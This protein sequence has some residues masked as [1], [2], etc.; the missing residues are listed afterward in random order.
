MFRNKLGGMS[1]VLAAALCLTVALSS[2][3]KQE[4]SPDLSLVVPEAA[5]Y[6]TTTVTVGD[7]VSEKTLPATVVYLDSAELTVE[8]SGAK[9]VEFLVE[10]DQQVEA[11]DPILTYQVEGSQADLTEKKLR[12]QEVENDYARQSSGYQSQI[13]RL[14][15]S[16]AECTKGTT[17]Y[18]LVNCNLKLVQSQANQLK[19][20]TAYQKEQ[21]KKEIEEAAEKLDVQ[22]LYA[23]FSG[24][25]SLLASIAEGDLIEN[26]LALC[27]MRSADRLLLQVENNPAF[28]YGDTVRIK[29]GLLS[30]AEG[31]EGRVVTCGRILP[32]KVSERVT[33]IELAD[34]ADVERLKLASGNLMVTADVVNLSDVLL[35]T[36]DAITTKNERDS[37]SLL[38]EDVLNQRYIS[39]GSKG[40]EESWVIGGLEEGQTV[41]VD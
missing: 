2:C 1:G 39:V 40:E 6:Q 19:L 41:V 14:K 34:S 33:Y 26:N 17:D 4:D 27:T 16:L 5:N 24:T 13:T 18:D 21:L 7:F 31:Y 25:V 8:E 9:F 10:R 12:L 20:E 35:L 29:A 23:P 11:G 32:G 30:G 28:R 38:E 36:N 3:G 37:V 22:T 15:N